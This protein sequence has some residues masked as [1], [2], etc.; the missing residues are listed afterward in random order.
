MTLETHPKFIDFYYAEEDTPVTIK[1]APTFPKTYIPMCENEYPTL[2]EI[3]GVYADGKTVVVSAEGKGIFSGLLKSLEDAGWKPSDGLGS[4]SSDEMPFSLVVTG[5]NS[6]DFY[7][8]EEPENDDYNG[9]TGGGTVPVRSGTFKYNEKNGELK[10]KFQLEEDIEVSG[11]LH[12][13][14]SADKKT[15]LVSGEV[16]G[17]VLVVVKFSVNISGSKER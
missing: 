10:L 5:K 17:R 3:E 2:A 11:T 6:G 13:T 4:D 16:S 15:V 14:Y 8:Y 9:N 1:I 12:C 7:K